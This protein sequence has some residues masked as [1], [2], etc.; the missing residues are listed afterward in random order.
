MMNPVVLSAST[1]VLSVTFLASIL[2]W[3]MLAGLVVLWFIDGKINKREVVDALFSLV[4]AWLVSEIVKSIFPTQRPFIENGRWPLTISLYHSEG[5]FP[6]AHA[7]MAFALSVNIYLHD[8]KVGLLYIIA[9][10][11]V[12][13]GRVWSNV[14]YPIDVI[15]G[16][17]LGSMIAIVVGKLRLYDMLLKLEVKRK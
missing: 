12:A 7:A 9:S 16:A 5:S 4:L 2:I 8:K 15:A 11:L 14:H 6:S 17:I 10:F 3:I 13:L 1:G